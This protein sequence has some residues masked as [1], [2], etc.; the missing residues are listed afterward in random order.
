MLSLAMT[1]YGEPLAERQCGDCTLCCSLLAIDR[2]ELRKAA[3]AACPHCDKGCTIYSR[4]P[5]VCVDFYCAWRLLEIFGPE[6]RPDLSG[7]YAQIEVDDVPPGF[8]TDHGIGLMLVANPL[9]TVRQAWFHDF[10]LTGLAGGIPL[11]LSL[12]GPARPSRGKAAS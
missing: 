3:G 12:P 11:F 5:P 10:V 6:W 2:A 9:K 4:R 7:V 8:A 1:L